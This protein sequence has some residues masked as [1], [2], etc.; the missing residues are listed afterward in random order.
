MVE[1]QSMYI[2][3]TMTVRV[4]LA[5]ALA[6]SMEPSGFPMMRSDVEEKKKECKEKGGRRGRCPL[7]SAARYKKESK[8]RRGRARGGHKVWLVDSSMFFPITRF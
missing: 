5:S 1:E 3:I 2:M 7:C 4:F 6:S 8:E